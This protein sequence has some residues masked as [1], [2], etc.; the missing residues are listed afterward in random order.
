MLMWKKKKTDTDDA[1]VNFYNDRRWVAN[2]VAMPNVSPLNIGLGN[3]D[4]DLLHDLKA[5]HHQYPEVRNNPDF[6]GKHRQRLGGEFEHAATSNKS[7]TMARKKFSL[8][9][10][11][12][13]YRP[14]V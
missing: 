1:N 7:S 12:S 6:I 2:A 10:Q 11:H 4:F 13:S 14:L 3:R 9:M 8:W 5:A